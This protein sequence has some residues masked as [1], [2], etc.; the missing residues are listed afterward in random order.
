MMGN[1]RVVEGG[2]VTR[3]AERRRVTAADI[4][5]EAQVSRATVGFVLN[6]TPGQTI[7]AATRTRVLDIAARLGYRPN[8]AAAALAGGR[9][10]IA[11]LVLS[12]WPDGFGVRAFVEELAQALDE[13][14]YSLVTQTY[15]PDRAR[16]LWE[17]L[18]PDVVLGTVAFTPEEVASMR[19]A[20]V[21]SLLPGPGPE[22]PV[23]AQ[24]VMGAAEGARLQVEHLRGLGHRRIAFASPSDGRLADHAQVRAS[25]AEEQAR[26][27]GV[28]W[29][30]TRTTDLADGSASSAVREWFEGQVTGIVAFNDDAAAAVIGAAIRQSIDVPAGLAV[31]GYDDSPLASL[32]VPSLSTIRADLTVIGRYVAQLVVNA[33]EGRSTPS[34]PPDIPIRVVVRESTIGRWQPNPV[35]P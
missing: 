11:L 18:S 35:R 1:R 21:R 9:S 13:S 34:E 12:D 22:K 4:A 6:N 28:E 25:L 8:R 14:G 17:T 32:L 29:A 30:G 23:T 7:S 15:T 2:K 19:A 10:R 24:V 3:P 31:I 27:A 20:G 26:D 33:A 16:P 5:R